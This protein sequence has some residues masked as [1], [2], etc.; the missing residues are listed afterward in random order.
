MMS[1]GEFLVRAGYT[2][3]TPDARGH[4]ESGGKI[5]T[6]GVLEAQDVHLWADWLLAHGVER[7]YGLGE[8]MGAAIL[9]ESL[10]REPRFRSVVA[11]CPFATFEEVARYRMAQTSG[12]PEWLFRRRSPRLGSRMRGCA[13]API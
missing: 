5:I 9:L 7:L 2:V 12:A 6:Y 8:S 13:T 3:L 10:A 1:H 4:G 11:E